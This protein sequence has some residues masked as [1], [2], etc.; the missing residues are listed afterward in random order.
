MRNYPWPF[1]LS[2]WSLQDLVDILEISSSSFFTHSS[3]LLSP[4]SHF[5]L[6]PWNCIWT[7]FDPNPLKSKAWVRIWLLR[8][9]DSNRL[10]YRAAKSLCT[11]DRF[12]PGSCPI[13]PPVLLVLFP[14][15]QCFLGTRKNN[16]KNKYLG[17][18]YSLLE[19]PKKCNR[20]NQI[21]WL[22]YRGEKNEIIETY[23]KPVLGFSL[24]DP[25][26]PTRGL[27]FI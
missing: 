5:S 21:Y 27:Y 11:Q 12:Y 13:C 2:L 9:E 24:P 7:R 15:H 19:I 4:L 26:P 14:Q 18:I 8:H 1:H 17:S 10:A 3:L 25:C 22:L 23:L 16:L 20:C 6:I